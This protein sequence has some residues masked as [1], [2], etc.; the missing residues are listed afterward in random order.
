MSVKSIQHNELKTTYP[1]IVYTIEPIIKQSTQI[2]RILR[3]E[4]GYTRQSIIFTLSWTFLC[5]H[6]KLVVY[7]TPILIAAILYHN[8][9]YS[10]EISKVETTTN[11]FEK[12]TAT[13]KDIQFEL[14]LILPSPENYDRFKQWYRSL[15][16]LSKA[17][18]LV[19]F[20]TVYVFWIVSLKLF[21]L[22]KIIWFLGCLA[23]T[24]CSSL[25]NVLCYSYHRAAFILRHANQTMVSQLQPVMTS[26]KQHLRT[27]SS[28]EHYDRFFRFNVLEH[29]RWWLAKGWSTLL[30]PNERPQW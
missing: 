4:E 1:D 22:D 24:W 17:Q 11:S 26:P 3:W 13:L 28:Q 16:A 9:H 14:A 8:Y 20:I 21:G 15:F 23:L 7:I 6:P 30:L 18:Q 12:L 19:R 27:S 5:L 29:Q 2:L 25:S 10:M